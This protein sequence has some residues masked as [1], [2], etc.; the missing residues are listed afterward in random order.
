MTDE[1][2][3]NANQAKD[4]GPLTERGGYTTRRH[5]HDRRNLTTQE[6]T[7]TI[8]DLLDSLFGDVNHDVEAQRFT[9]LIPRFAQAL[10]DLC[11]PFTASIETGTAGVA[12]ALT[13]PTGDLR[14][15]DQLLCMLEDLALTRTCRHT[16]ITR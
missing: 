13:S 15:A 9:G 7:R 1:T 2:G 4:R 5:N 12:L 14:S 3:S 10:R 11:I 6:L 8:D 16:R